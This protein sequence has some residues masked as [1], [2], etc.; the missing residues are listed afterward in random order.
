MAAAGDRDVLVFDAIGRSADDH[1]VADLYALADALVFP[2]S[3]EGFGLPI[4]EAAADRLPIVCSD[5]PVLRSLAGS[6]AT[7]VPVTGDG[8]AFAEGIEHALAASPIAQL[9][10]RVRRE[11][12]WRHIVNEQVIPA[13]LG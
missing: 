2:S 12:D 3:S 11:S 13:I 9:A 5:L 4:L 6:A 7:Y 1:E 10:G 8:V